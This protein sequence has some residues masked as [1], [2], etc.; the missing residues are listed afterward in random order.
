MKLY[1]FRRLCEYCKS[2]SVRHPRCDDA[3]STG[4]LNQRW[5]RSVGGKD[6]WKRLVEKFGGKSSVG[7]VR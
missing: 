1:I 7:K 4:H 3:I 5:E 2:Y 6:W